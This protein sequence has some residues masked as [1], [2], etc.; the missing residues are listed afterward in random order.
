MIFKKGELFCGPGGISLGAKFAEFVHNGEVFGVEH[1]WAN[2][3]DQVA[4]ETFRYNICPDKPETVIHGDVRQLNIE[5]LPKIDAFAF[6]FP[7]NDYS[8]I[9]ESKGLEGSY[10]PLYSY[11]IKVLNHHQPLWFIAENVGGLESANG[12]KAFVKILKEMENSGYNLTP[13]LYLFERYGIPQARRRIIIVGIRKDLGWKFQVP[14]ATHNDTLIYKT[15]R[16]ALEEPPIPQNAFNHEFTVHKKKVVEMLNH[17]PPGQNAWY[18]EIPKNL[19]LN[20]KGARLSNIYK[21]LHPDKPAYTVTGSGGGGTHMYHYDEPRALTNREK[22]RI[23]TFPDSFKFLGRK[24][25]V[26][27]QIGMA[28]PPQGA[29]V[30]IEAIFKAFAGI[31][32]ETEPSKWENDLSDMLMSKSIK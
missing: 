32:Y 30:I 26:R 14:K 31:Q 11:G 21:R 19:Q 17:I 20:V 7:C 18:E 13:H 25:S 23:Q 8:I 6:G 27:R 16:Q 2:D 22:A 12:G 24:E 5:N 29:K 9:G 28:V 3:L 4:C 15:S 1:V 10:G